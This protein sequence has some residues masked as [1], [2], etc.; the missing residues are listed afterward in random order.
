MQRIAAI[1]TLAI[2]MLGQGASSV[3]VNTLLP[4]DSDVFEYAE[5]SVDAETSQSDKQLLRD[6]I[7]SSY[8]ITR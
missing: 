7:S 5:I 2:T 4:D 3:Q 8:N 6:M 1:S